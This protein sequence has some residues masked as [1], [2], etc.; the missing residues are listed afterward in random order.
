MSTATLDPRTDA[1]APP[2]LAW[3]WE[4]RVAAVRN[5][6]R[7]A[8]A[9]RGDFL[10]GFFSS[11]LVPVAIQ[12]L[13]WYSIFK[14]SGQLLFAGMSYQEL[15]AYTWASML[16]S[17]VRGGNYDFGLIEMIRTGTLS[18]YLLRPVGVVEFTFYRALGEKLITVGFCFV[19]GGI[20]IAFT[21]LHFHHLLMGM[22]LAI[23]GNVIG[24]LFGAV[25]GAAAFYW[26]NAFAIIMVKNM[27]VSL[28]SG[29]L[30]PLSIVPEQY[31]WVWKSTPFYLFVY[32]PTQV[33]LGKWSA[34]V[35]A[36]QMVIGIA[37]TIA[38]WLALR[39]SWGYSIKR[40]Q[41]IGG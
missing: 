17:Q 24:Y 19:A 18:N 27:F 5:G 36:E 13:L 12:L 33:T 14:A 39:W 28:F 22:L 41:G 37:W 15:L 7:D 38:L 35:W 8:L 31:S 30:I 4:W 2:T 10:I 26:E 3:H 21:D 20:A 11:A 1:P 6:M 23:L 25:L 9:Y 40:Y 34:G 32:G 29:E 16:F